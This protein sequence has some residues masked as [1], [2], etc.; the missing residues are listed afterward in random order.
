MTQHQ[1]EQRQTG[2]KPDVQLEHVTETP[3]PDNQELTEKP[4]V[5]DEHREK[6]REMAKAYSDDLKTTTLPGS[7]GTVS[8]TSVTDWVDDEDKGK[9]ETSADEGNV[10]YRNTEEFRKKLEE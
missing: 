8:G 1:T 7:S 2:D 5:T 9:I 10:E 3:D 4:E 6:A